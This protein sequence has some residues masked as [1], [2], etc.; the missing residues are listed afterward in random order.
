MI[1]KAAEVAFKA[2]DKAKLESFRG[3]ATGP[4]LAEIE[5]M[6]NQLK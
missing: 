6:I 4:Q 1:A 2:K 5:R 3:R